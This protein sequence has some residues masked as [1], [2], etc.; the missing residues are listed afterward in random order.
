MPNLYPQ[1]TT[2]LRLPLFHCYVSAG[3]PSPAEDYIEQ[4]LDLN[5]LCIAHPAASYLVRVNGQS[6]LNAGIHN[7][8]I[9]VV[10]RAL[11]AKQGDII[12]ACVEGEF[13]VKEL[14]L[15][16]PLLIAHNPQFSNIALNTVSDFELFGVV[17]SVIR[18]LK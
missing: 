8:D 7:N 1:F 17:R 3:F 15:K 14:S 12:V 13:T 4:C 2:A 10:D 11:T 5:E 9:L 16:P 18:T 6:M